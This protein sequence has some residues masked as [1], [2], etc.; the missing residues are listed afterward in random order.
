MLALICFFLPPRTAHKAMAEAKHK[1][2]AGISAQFQRDYA[3]A[4][5]R[6]ADDTVE[7]RERVAKVQDLRTLYELTDAFPV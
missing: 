7:L 5:A 4:T 3:E 6:L 2:L 1:L